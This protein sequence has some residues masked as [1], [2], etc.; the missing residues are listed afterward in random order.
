MPCLVVVPATPLLAQGVSGGA[1]ALPGLRRTVRDVLSGELAVSRGG[2]AVLATGPTARAGRLRPSLAAV[3]V[4]DAFVP[5]MSAFGPRGED[6]DGIAAPGA[7]VALLALGDAG[8]DVATCPVDVVEV[9]GE[10]ATAAV[11]A[12]TARI[13]ATFDDQAVTSTA[14]GLLVVADQP[15]PG[16]DAVLERLLA[17]GRWTHDVLDVHQRHEHLPGSYSVTVHRL[18]T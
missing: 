5:L 4:A 7:S 6:W 14:G 18:V 11:L 17:S 2:V 9:P 8:L 16:V 1:D 15:A 10:P 12:A 13:R 3:G